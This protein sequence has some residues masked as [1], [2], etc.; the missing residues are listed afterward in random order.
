MRVPTPA[1]AATPTALPTTIPATAPVDN[2]ASSP[3]SSLPEDVDIDGA[4]DDAVGIIASPAVFV[5]AG[6]GF[7][8]ENGAIVSVVLPVR[9][10]AASVLALVGSTIAETASMYNTLPTTGSIMLQAH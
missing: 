2:P 10:M 4:G 3:S 8:D 6:A 1:T 9:L 7:A 5:G